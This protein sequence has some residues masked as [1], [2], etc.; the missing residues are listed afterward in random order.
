MRR[1]TIYLLTLGAE[2]IWLMGILAAPYLRSKGLDMVSDGVYDAYRVVCHQKAERS[3]F[4][5]GEKMAVCARCFGI[6]VGLLI[7]TVAIPIYGKIEK[8]RVPDYRLALL[9]L[10]P[11]AI[12]GF[13]QLSGLRESSNELRLLTGFLFGLMFISYFIPLVLVRMGEHG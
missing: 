6:Y 8:I 12:D 4:L 13:S 1:R 10:V 2:C 11:L 3:L 7:G 9:S 5:F